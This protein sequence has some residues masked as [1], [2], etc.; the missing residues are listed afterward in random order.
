MVP[1]SSEGSKVSH[2]TRGIRKLMSVFDTGVNA[3]EKAKTRTSGPSLTSSHPGSRADQPPRFGP[4]S[5]F[6]LLKGLVT[7]SDLTAGFHEATG[8]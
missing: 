8:C 5:G 7:E 6:S 2:V 4:A 1:P 3:P